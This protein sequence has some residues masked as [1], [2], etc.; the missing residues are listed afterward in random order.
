MEQEVGYSEGGRNSR[1]ALKGSGEMTSLVDIYIED[2]SPAWRWRI[3]SG[4]PE[5]MDSLSGVPEK[6]DS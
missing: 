2:G 1:R 3:M 4:A 6:K 5:S